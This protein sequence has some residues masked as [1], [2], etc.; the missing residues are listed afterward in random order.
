[1]MQ[2]EIGNRNRNRNKRT[3]VLTGDELRE[4][5]S[6]AAVAAR[7][8]S[9]AAAFTAAVR[10]E[11]VPLIPREDPGAGVGDVDGEGD[12]PD[13]PLR[14]AVVVESFIFGF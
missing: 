5:E 7:R 4:R 8:A 3:A 6:D 1:M 12:E 14:L 13:V 2:I 9:A 11:Y 10:R